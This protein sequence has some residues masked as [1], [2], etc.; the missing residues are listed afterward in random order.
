MADTILSVR[1]LRVEFR[2]SGGALEAVSGVDLD[3]ERGGVLGIVGES[4]SGKSVAFKSLMGLLPASARITGNAQFGGK[5][6]LTL[7]ERAMRSIRGNRIAMIFQD[8][9]TAFNP[10]TTIGAQIAEMIHL[11][12]RS[13]TRAHLRE[14]TVRL[15]DMVSIPEARA[16][17]DAYPH[18]FS[19]GMRQ[20]VMI[21]MALANEPELL[22]ADEPTTALDVTVQAQ[23]L[24]VLRELQERL[25]V[26]LILITHDLGVV[27]GVADDVAVMYSGRVVERANVDDL[28]ADP[29]HPYTRGLIASVPVLDTTGGQPMSEPILELRDLVKEFPVGKT[30]LG[31]PLRQ[32]RAVSGVSL[33]VHRGETF[34]IVGES[35]CGKSTLGR[36][37]MRLLKP[38]SGQ[39]HF[40]GEN[41]TDI[42]GAA[43]RQLR[44][45]MQIVFQ[46]PFA[47]LHPRMRIGRILAEPLLIAGMPKTQREARI[48][49]LLSLVGLNREHAGRYPH[50][51]SG[52]QRQRVGIARALASDPALIV[53]DEPVS[54]LDVSIQA[55]VLNL[56][57]DL[58][59]E[60]NLS[61][62]FIAHDLSV[63]RHI[64]D[65]VAVM[66][67]GKIVEV[68]DVDQI[69]NNPRHP[70]T[71]ALLSAAPVPDPPRERERQ[72]VILKGD[73]PS[74]LNPP[75]GCRFRTRCWKA[76]ALCAE[77]VPALEG[78]N[79]DHT[80][81]CHFPL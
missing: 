56:L 23:V 58:K 60:L 11:H 25:N 77:V 16:R 21:A 75:S 72:R 80:A 53:L 13:L 64:C 68:G 66:Y 46:D 30:V 9:L 26:S 54:A 37:V 35:G 55:G 39:V 5:N 6:L 81:A 29:R 12:D 67:L 44:Q 3:L 61:Y 78:K 62:V 8:P 1:D 65:R 4:G 69:Y 49:D 42:S 63:I 31:T 17:V 24:D 34:G 43:L 76:E 51:I 40:E 74:P 59:R 50:E 36:C 15:L 10:V 28:F 70:Y 32:L 47:S 38:T 22:I 19:G 7:P 14:R 45:K 20:R 18:E 27:A 52:G 41:I 79:E 48:D 57:D 71:K 33:D 73:L 2:T